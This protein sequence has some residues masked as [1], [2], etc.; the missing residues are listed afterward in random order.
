ML[1]KYMKNLNENKYMRVEMELGT[2]TTFFQI[3]G[4]FAIS[5][6]LWKKGHHSICVTIYIL[7][8]I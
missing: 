1:N 4:C 3:H 6:L 2:S 7:G 5:I 8:I